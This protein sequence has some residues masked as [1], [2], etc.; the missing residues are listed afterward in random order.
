MTAAMGAGAV[1]GGLF[2][3]SR[4]RS[5]LGMSVAAGALFGASV[6]LT[7]LMPTLHLA[8][9]SLLIV[10]FFSITFTSLANVT[11]QLS[12]ASEMQ[13]RVM[14]L[15]SMAFL[16]TTPIGGPVMGAIGEHAGARWALAIGGFAAIVAAGVGLRAWMRWRVEGGGW[17]ERKTSNGKP[18]TINKRPMSQLETRNEKLETPS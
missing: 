10:G 17:R 9:A 15:W 1:V 6:M 11:L 8:V 14:S 3:A 4:R 12:S 16:G 7:A 18:E 13:G 5:T 2:A